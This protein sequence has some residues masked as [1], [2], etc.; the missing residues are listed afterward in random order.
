[1]SRPGESMSVP[2]PRF[3]N[4]WTNWRAK[5]WQSWSSRR[6]CPKF[7]DCVTGVYVMR[8]GRIAAEY[9][10]AEATPEKLLASAL[11]SAS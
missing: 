7:W 2:R 9:A 10:R 8:E 11:P 1:M 4:C 3:I 6:K 5:G